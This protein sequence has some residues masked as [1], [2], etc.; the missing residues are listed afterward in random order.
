MTIREASHAGSWYTDDS[1]TLARDLDTW[2]ARVDESIQGVGDIPIDRARVIIAP[3]VLVPK[4]TSMKA[5]FA[6]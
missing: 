5:G 2:L 3:Y 4:V 6:S 1:Q